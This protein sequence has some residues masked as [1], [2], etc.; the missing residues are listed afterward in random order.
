M[1]M[2]RR[3]VGGIRALI[4]N[5]HVER[6][7]DAELRDYL[8]AAVDRKVSAGMSRTDAERAAR[9]EIGSLEALKDRVRDV[10]WESRIEMLLQD[11]RYA[12]RMVRRAPGVAVVVVVTIAIGVGAATSM[13][14]IM[15]NLLLAPLR[16]CRRIFRAGA[17]GCRNGSRCDT[18]QPHVECSSPQ[19][20]RRIDS[21]SRP[22]YPARLPDRRPVLQLG[23]TG[24][25][26][27]DRHADQT[28][29][30]LPGAGT[31]SG[32]CAH[33]ERDDGESVL[34]WPIADRGVRVSTTRDGVQDRGG[35][36][37]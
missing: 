33:R 37:C 15:R 20:P 12:A 18:G 14:S 31:K 7:L 23:D 36:R 32:G 24:I 11:L 21:A 6:E 22:R 17:R 34:A 4:R 9:V 8:D 25:L 26:R 30:R 13:F 3:V 5:D 1:T 2:L 10:G 29:A 27:N 28:G 19:R 35:R 16:R